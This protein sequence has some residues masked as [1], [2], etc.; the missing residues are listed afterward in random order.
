MFASRLWFWEN[1]KDCARVKTSRTVQ[2]TAPCSEK[3]AKPLL[4]GSKINLRTLSASQ[5]K[6]SISF[7]L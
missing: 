1:W 3:T 4:S 6:V 2:T 7:H 5:P